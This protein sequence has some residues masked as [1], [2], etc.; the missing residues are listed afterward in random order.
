[1]PGGTADEFD[2][3]LSRRG[4]VAVVAREVENVLAE[5]G[6]KVFVQDYDIPLG[7]SF[8]EAMHEA[9]KKSRDLVVLFSRDYEGSPFTRKE[10]T[11]FEADRHFGSQD[12]Q[13]VVLRCE[14]VP[15]RGLLADTVY[16]DLVGVTDAEERKRRIIAA[17]ERHSSAQ[18]PQRR[19]GRTFVGVPPRIAS[20]TGRADALDR[21][22]SIL[23]RDKS[24]AVTQVG[25][26]AVQG[27]GGVGKT[28][29]AVEYAHRFRNLYDGVW[30]CPAETRTG[31]LSSLRDLAAEVGVASR[32]QADIEKAAKLALQRLTE[33]QDIWL[34]VYDNVVAPEE[35]ADLLPA[36]GA[37]VLITSRFADWT[38]WAEEV[39]LDV[40]PVE[41]AI[42]L[43]QSRAGRIDQA[44]ARTVADTLGG[45]PLALDHAAATCKRTQMSFAVYAR[46][47]SSF[48]AVAP[49]G[50]GYPRSVA[51]TFD[52]AINDA[53]SQCLKAEALMAFL[54]CCAPERIPMTLV[55]GAIQNEI[56]RM[57]AVA[58]LSEVS[59]VK[60]DPFDNGMAAITV[61]RIVQAVMRRRTADL[62]MFVKEITRRAEEIFPRRAF[63]NP[64]A[65]P[66]CAALLPHVM[67]LRE[68]N[69]T[70]DRE[71]LG[72][73]A[74]VL[75]FAAD[76]LFARYAYGQSEL[77]LREAIAAGKASLGADDPHV[78]EMLDSLR[79]VLQSVGRWGEASAI[80]Q[81]ARR[82]HE[83]RAG[84]EDLDVI[85]NRALDLERAG[86]VAEAE[87]LY[88]NALAH[89]EEKYGKEH[90]NIT[91][92]LDALG[93]FLLYRRPAEAED[94]FRRC[95]AIKNA[96][97]EGTQSNW[98][99]VAICMIRLAQFCEEAERYAEAEQF[100]RDALLI[101]DKSQ[102]KDS[103]LADE[104]R[105]M[106]ANLL[107]KVGNYQEAEAIYRDLLARGEQADNP[108]AN[109]W[110]G[111]AIVLYATGR[112]AEAETCCQS[113]VDT[114]ERL[115]GRNSVGFATFLSWMGCCLEEAHQFAQAE[116]YC[117][118]AIEILQAISAE[119]E[120]MALALDRLAMVLLRG[121][122]PEEALKHGTAALAMYEKD[123]GPFIPFTPVCAKICVSALIALGRS[124]EANAL[125]THYNVPA[126]VTK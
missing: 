5:K 83:I 22:D 29:L 112:A 77:V 113:A 80:G 32:D 39:S 43:L 79:M 52:L 104:H 89:Q 70:S 66:L 110:V 18:R 67:M 53:V 36:A 44:G 123:Y 51:A 49:R 122:H 64:S 117:R 65:W 20:F 111:L 38:C 72:M 87:D 105:G 81:E 14:D 10:F 99:S 88:R 56:E 116:S 59:L 50:T 61:H 73:R 121:G 57:Q 26:A 96:L 60:H 106:F 74:K 3:F 120:S 109:H 125:S 119:P 124:E 42:A 6:Y 4:S 108:I 25:R 7:A 46:K 17:A 8:I 98:P 24:V 76:F 71:L 115:Q 84:P 102:Q 85:R 15:L 69:D 37:R 28:S 82:I 93:I 118:N 35:I 19:R 126:E 90:Q 103:L 12:R 78:G 68:Y 95:L 97:P 9:I 101:F 1:M 16:Q 41:E 54:A 100:Y 34:L 48:I 13:I 21:L 45:L 2:F 33:Q 23:T 91:P 11:S 114:Q 75:S 27:M 86:R 62:K 92:Y 31:L 58:A 47:A 55:E 30:W 107:T 63:R 40:L 94:L